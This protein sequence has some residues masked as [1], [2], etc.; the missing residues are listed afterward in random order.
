[1]KAIKNI[2]SLP[3]LLS[4]EDPCWQ[5]RVYDSTKVIPVVRKNTNDITLFSACGYI[6]LD[7]DAKYSYSKGK[8]LTE[9]CEINTIGALVDYILAME[10]YQDYLLDIPLGQFTKA[11]LFWGI[12]STLISPKS[13]QQRTDG[14]C[15]QDWG[16]YQIQLYQNHIDLH[17][18]LVE[19]NDGSI[20]I[21][22]I[23]NMALVD[24]LEKVAFEMNSATADMN[25][26][27]VYR[28]MIDALQ[29]PPSTYEQLWSKL[30]PGN[31]F[32][33]LL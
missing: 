5:K 8:D 14:S 29:P 16:L 1:M 15:T 30:C 3:L 31:E 7:N 13:N 19:Y 17:L 32:D 2:T 28:V 25:E 20:W 18:L 23:P 9:Y 22:H 11:E 21:D 12:W 10:S 24:A 26:I 6:D 33:W 4:K 27:P